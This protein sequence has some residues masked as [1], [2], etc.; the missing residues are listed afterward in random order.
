MNLFDPLSAERRRYLTRRWFFRDCGVGLGTHCPRHRCSANRPLAPPA[1]ADPMAPGSRTSQARPSASST[2]SWAAPQPPGAVRQQ[3]AARQVRRHAAAAGAAQELPGR[4][5]QPELQA[6]SGRSSS[7][8]GTARPAP[9]CGTAPAPG[10][11]VDDIAI[12]KSMVTDAFNHAPA[13]IFMNTG[14]SSSAGRAWARGSPTVSAA[15]RRTCPASSSSRQRQQG[16]ERRA[17]RAGGQRFLPTSTRHAV[18]HRGR[19]GAVPLEPGRDRFRDA[20]GLARRHQGAQ[21]EAARRRSATPRSRRGSS[22][23]RWPAACSR[24][25]RN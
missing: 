1:V 2:C 13:Q 14:S 10:R 18:P 3:A 16:A 19:P 4:V 21:R 23:T 6:S 5:H 20:E 25:H 9:S 22:P 12:V 15:S 24:A 11:V 8:P 7:S 17:T